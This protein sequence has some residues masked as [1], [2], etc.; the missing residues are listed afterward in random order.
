[1]VDAQD[2][3]LVP[4]PFAPLGSR[5][6]GAVRVRVAS[7]GAW[8]D[9]SAAAAVEVALLGPADWTATFVTPKEIGAVGSPAPVL[10]R[11]FDM[12]GPVA[13]ARLYTTALGV[14]EAWLNGRRVGDEILAPGWTSFKNRLCY[15]SF[16]VTALLV[17]GENTFEAMLGNGWYRGQLTWLKHRDTYGDRLAYL[18]QLEVTYADGGGR[19]PGNGWFVAG[20]R[21]RGARRRPL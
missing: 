6:R 9:W 3:V 12:S 20:G 18:A 19:A 14:Y 10:R 8:T 1:M 15:Q 7:A 13:S 17:D 5:Q 21:E 4:W 16:D 11:Q 2:Q